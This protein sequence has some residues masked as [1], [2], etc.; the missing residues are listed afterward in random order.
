MFADGLAVC[1]LKY[2]LVRVGSMSERVPA[3]HTASSC[4]AG[5]DAHGK[6]LTP[7]CGNWLGKA[8][9]HQGSERSPCAT[10]HSLGIISRLV[11]TV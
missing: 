7:G 3:E 9:K 1:T 10:S 4:A 8:Q 6:D 11:L 2:V 5:T